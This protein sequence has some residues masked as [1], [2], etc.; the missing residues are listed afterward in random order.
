MTTTLQ[1][2]WFEL[3]L[4]PESGLF[5]LNPAAVGLPGLTGC[6][7]QIEIRQYF[8]KQKITLDA[9]DLTSPS[10]ASSPHGPLIQVSTQCPD[11]DSGI[12]ATITFAL[13]QERPLFLWKI[14]LQNAGPEP[15]WLERIEFL[16]VGGQPG[17]SRDQCMISFVINA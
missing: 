12:Q 8:R 4:H 2:P 17:R 3:I 14:D 9:W 5:D 16:R 6:R 10:E 11:H 1:S 15:V 7:M 13:A